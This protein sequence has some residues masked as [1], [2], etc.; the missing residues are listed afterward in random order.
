MVTKKCFLQTFVINQT[1]LTG[2]GF[3]KIFFH[4]CFFTQLSSVKDRFFKQQQKTRLTKHVL[5]KTYFNFSK[6]LFQEN[7]LIY[8]LQ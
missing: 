7:H 5:Q 8:N 4:K 1:H 6:N 3:F 2:K